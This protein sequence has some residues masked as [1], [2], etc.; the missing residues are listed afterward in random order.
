MFVVGFGV[1]VVW[2]GLLVVGLFFVVVWLWC[3]GLCSGCEGFVWFLGLVLWLGGLGVFGC[4]W[5]FW[6]FVWCWVLGLFGC[7]VGLG[8]F[9]LFVWVVGLLVFGCWFVGCLFG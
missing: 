8:W 9:G 4:V 3:F 6:V 7:L 2:V 5:V 1:E